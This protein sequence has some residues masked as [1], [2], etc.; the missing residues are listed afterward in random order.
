MSSTATAFAEVFAGYPSTAWRAPG[1][2][3]L[4]GEHTDY[5]G[6]L[7]LPFAIPWD[8]R[9]AAR[10]RTGGLLR[11]ASR[12]HPGEI[13]EVPLDGLAPG[14]VTG[15]AAYVAGTAWALAENGHVLVGADLL[16][17]GDV[18]LGAG[19]SSSAAL[20]CASACALLTASGH[21]WDPM[22]MAVVAQRG[23][24]DFVG[25]PCG[26]M[27]QAAAMLCRT[28][29]AL[30]L[31]CATLLSRHVPLDPDAHG[32]TMLTIDTRAPHQLVDGAYAARRTSC[33]QAAALLGVR[34]LGQ[35]P[36][37]ELDAALARLDDPV[38]RR[39]AR[40][41]ITEV[42]RV[43]QVVAL[44]DAGDLHAVGRLLDASHASLRDDFEVSVPA[45]DL[46]VESAREAGA[47]GARMTGAGFGGSVVVLVPQD[48]AHD[49][50][51]AVSSRFA[52]AGF[53]PPVPMQVSPS[54]GAG[55][56]ELG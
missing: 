39:R 22:Q 15:W 16:V 55:P 35:V 2:V 25:M 54:T 23:E 17:D 43:T 41:V 18:P 8:V 24:N 38:L 36:A 45:L 28:G 50:T 44:L 5:N 32:L 12:Q 47:V 6:G 46:A 4:I 26:V 13:V 33:D 14:A 51:T 19:M 9:V 27:D 42:D 56:L 37:A 7:V 52:A 48:S 20:E 31:D 21:G 3:N 34:H 29:H 30:L 10:P 49:V 11:I 53:S 1:R 40:H